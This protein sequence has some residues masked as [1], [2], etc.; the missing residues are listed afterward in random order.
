MREFVIL[1]HGD[2]RLDYVLQS[3][4]GTERLWFMGH[5]Y[6]WTGCT[7]RGGG[8]RLFIREGVRE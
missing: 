1:T 2:W 7:E 4:R 5:W 6:V 8:K 3:N